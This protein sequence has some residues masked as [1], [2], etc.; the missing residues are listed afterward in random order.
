MDGAF[1]NYKKV[2]IR[3]KTLQKGGGGRKGREFTEGKLRLLGQN[4][5]KIPQNLVWA[6]GGRKE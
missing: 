5:A 6:A 4:G 2:K 3:R 1:E